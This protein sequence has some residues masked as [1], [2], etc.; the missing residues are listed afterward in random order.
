VIVL[1]MSRGRSV[2]Y[3]LG[4][5]SVIARNVSNVCDVAPSST[6][7]RGHVAERRAVAPRSSRHPEGVP[8]YIRA[9]MRCCAN[10]CIKSY[11][12]YSSIASR[13][14]GDSTG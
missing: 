2:T 11:R 12:H 4:T 9:G 3:V 13:N 6:R 7:A 8:M 5:L 1:P 10:F 14:Q